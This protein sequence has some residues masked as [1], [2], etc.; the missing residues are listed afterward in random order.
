MRKAVNGLSVLVEQELELNPFED[1][2][3][4]LFCNRQRRILKA[5][6]WDAN[7]FC[8][9]TKRLEKHRFPWPNSHR[10]VREITEEELKMLLTGIDFWHSHE[11]LHYQTIS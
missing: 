7:G 5:L 1:G 11:R 4:F 2:A 6:Y 8:L 9:W 10:Q 3:V